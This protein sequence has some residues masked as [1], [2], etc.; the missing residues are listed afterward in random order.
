VVNAVVLRPLPFPDADRL[1]RIWHT[2]PQGVFTTPIF[3]LSPGNFIDWEAQS[4]SF[5]KMAIYQVGR[6]TMT[7]QGEPDAVVT[8]RASADFLPILGIQPSIGR[9]FTTD[10]DRSGGPRTAMLSN[11]LF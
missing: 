4:Q 7:G 1:M 10:E 11:R 9:G 3:A 6:Q 5:E 2:P 8:I